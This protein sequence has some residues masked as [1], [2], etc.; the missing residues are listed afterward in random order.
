MPTVLDILGQEIPK[1]VEGRS[2]LPAMRDLSTRGR[3]FVV[4][5]H[6]FSNPRQVIRSVD[7]QEHETEGSDTTIT[8]EEWSLL[9]YPEP[10]QSWLYHLPSDPKQEKNV[11]EKHPDVA[12][13]LHQMLVKFMYDTN[14]PSEL[15]DPR[16][17]L[18]L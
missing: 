14:L 10:G 18:K 15:R 8:T 13:E 12:R 5:T 16:M 7:G 3:E 17:K 4:T 11:I 6:P 9:Y 1:S 2:L